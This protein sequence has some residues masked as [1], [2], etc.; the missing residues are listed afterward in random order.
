MELIADAIR[1]ELRRH[2]W[3]QADLARVLGWSVQTISEIMKGK[4]RI[5]APMALD[6]AEVSPDKAA[7]D[8]LALQNTVDL[9]DARRRQAGTDR[10][11]QIEQRAELENRVPVREL[12]RRGAVSRSDPAI[13]A[14]EVAALIGDDP[15]FGASAKRQVTEAPFT[16]AQ[17]AWIALA[18]H[19][20]MKTPLPHYNEESFPVVA[21]SL[22]RLVTT[23]TNFSR[24]PAMFAAFGVALVHV[25]PFPGGRIDGVSL[26]IGENP[27]IAI[28]GRGRRFD[29]VLFALLHECAHIVEGHWRDAPRLHEDGKELAVGDS[30]VEDHVNALAAEWCF[31]G[32]L[33]KQRPVSRHDVASLATKHGVAQA[34]VI[35]NLQHD[36]I[37]EW[38]SALSRGLPTV[39]EELKSWT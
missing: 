14:A 20:A 29:K 16:R 6:L 26:A 4:R 39:E 38:S 11:K 1:E 36:K 28:S 27:M 33:Q 13:Q 35:G 3:A 34:L 17:T 25:D 8:W 19:K 24:L 18:R 10:Q 22:P 32:G 21:G 15:T 12:I 9:D 37:I 2:D 5:D 31:P 23:P 30:A 7:A